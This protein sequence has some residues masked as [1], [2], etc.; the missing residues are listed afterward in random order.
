V[1]R[2]NSRQGYLDSLSTSQSEPVVGFPAQG[3]RHNLQGSHEKA[4]SCCDEVSSCEE[5]SHS[6]EEQSHLGEDDMQGWI[7]PWSD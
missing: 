6:C 5:Q 4:C 2:H 7:C 1:N 3:V